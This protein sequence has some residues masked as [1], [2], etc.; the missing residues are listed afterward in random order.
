MIKIIPSRKSQIARV[1]RKRTISPD[2]VFITAKEFSR[3]LPSLFSAIA[4]GRP[5][6]YVY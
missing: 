2:S 6:W 1:L 5:V 4:N 3:A